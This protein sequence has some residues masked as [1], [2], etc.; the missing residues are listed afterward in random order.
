MRSKKRVVRES[1]RQEEKWCTRA[2]I[3]SPIFGNSLN[4]NYRSCLLK[5]LNVS[6]LFAN[7]GMAS[8]TPGRC[9]SVTIVLTTASRF[10]QPFAQTV[11]IRDTDGRPDATPDCSWVLV[12]ASPSRL[13][14]EFGTDPA[15]ESLCLG[16][17]IEAQDEK[18]ESGEDEDDLHDCSGD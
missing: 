12:I 15:T 14:F 6:L 1:T 17:L 7:T 18:E 16:F 10:T 11:T 13:L 3:G 9:I 5:E 4:N 8:G 2:G